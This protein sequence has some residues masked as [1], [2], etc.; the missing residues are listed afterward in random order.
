VSYSFPPNSVSA[1][2]QYAI[3][4]D[5]SSGGFVAGAANTSNPYGGGAAYLFSGSWTLLSGGD[6]DLAFQTFVTSGTSNAPDPEFTLTKG[7]GQA[8]AGPFASSLTAPV[9]STVWYQLVLTNRDPNGF[10]GL[11][12]V[13]SGA[14]GTFPAAC[15]AIPSPFNAGST[16][17]CTY[18]STVGPGTTENTAVAKFGPTQRRATAT[19]TALGAIAT[20]SPSFAPTP[21]PT[22]IA[23]VGAG[24]AAPTPPDTDASPRAAAEGSVPTVLPVVGILA[25]VSTLIVL[26]VRRRPSSS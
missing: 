17:T 21:A 19:V 12:L 14:G 13:D 3:V 16:Y 4:I 23:S 1:G 6:V 24:G 25:F 7:V 20:P 26:A 11:T 22:P 18:S 5:P 10:V 9:G 15:P 8:Q 2:T